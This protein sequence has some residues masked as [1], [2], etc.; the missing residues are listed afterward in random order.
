MT[1]NTAPKPAST[2]IPAPGELV[3]AVM[4][5]DREAV[6]VLL[7]EREA[8]DVNERYAINTALL[9]GAC[10]GD[11]EIVRLLLDHGAEINAQ[12]LWDGDGQTALIIA[13]S[14]GDEAIVR[15]LM[16][17]KAD[18]WV[19]DKKGKTALDRAEEYG[20]TKV[21]AILKDA[22]ELPHRLAVQAVLDAVA[23]T[24]RLLNECL[25]APRGMGP[26]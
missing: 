5:R 8:F 11:P 4:D 1:G 19:R 17:R 15:L 2:D 6:R 26:S 12:G 18:L 22:M 10:S 16:D 7:K 3:L 14:C 20:H 21:A 25:P 23:R 9:E 13:A 24:Q